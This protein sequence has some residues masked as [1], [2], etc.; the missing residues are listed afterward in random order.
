MMIVVIAICALIALIKNLCLDIFFNI[1]GAILG[2][3][4]FYY[5]PLLVHQKCIAQKKV[6]KHSE[7]TWSDSETNSLQSDK[8]DM[9]MCPYSVP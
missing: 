1:E 3:F 6:K 8:F 5:I 7:M 9:P 4:T 2:F